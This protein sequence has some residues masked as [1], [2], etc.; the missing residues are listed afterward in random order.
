MRIINIIIIIIEQ[1]GT[2]KHV[3]GI[4]EVQMRKLIQVETT[5]MKEMSTYKQN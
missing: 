3:K 4:Q 1:D 2:I 5:K